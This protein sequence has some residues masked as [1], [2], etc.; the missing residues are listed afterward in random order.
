MSV[1]SD[2]PPS[3]A[4]RGHAARNAAIVVGVVLVALIALLA[5]RGAFESPSSK[6]IGQVAPELTGETLDG[7]PFSLAQHRGQVGRVLLL[8]QVQQVRRRAHADQPLDRGQDDVDFA[9]CHGS[10]A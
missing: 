6:K 8:Q 7:D 2:A 9:L 10:R 4:R 5:T 1:T 3:P